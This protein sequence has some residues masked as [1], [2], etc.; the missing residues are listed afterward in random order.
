MG[1]T[2]LYYSYILG[3]VGVGCLVAGIIDDALEIVPGLEPV[4]WFLIAI[5]LFILGR[6]VWAAAMKQGKK[7]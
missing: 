4:S 3:W 7:D 6:W 2:Y 5:S 1:K